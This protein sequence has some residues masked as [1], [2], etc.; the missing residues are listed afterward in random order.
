MMVSASLLS[1]MAI[2]PRPS[3]FIPTNFI[4]SITFF[5][6]LLSLRTDAYVGGPSLRSNTNP[7]ATDQLSRSLS[8]PHPQQVRAV[9]RLGLKLLADLDANGNQNVFISPVSIS[10]VLRLLQLG[11]TVMSD[12]EREIRTL[13]G[14]GFANLTSLSDPDV[15][16]FSANSIWTTILVLGSY[17]S[18]VTR[19]FGAKV[20]PLPSD[21]SVI[22]KWVS[23]ATRG[24]ILTL[25]EEF[26][27]GQILVLLINAI[28]FKA[29][30]KIAFDPSRTTNNDFFGPRGE[31]GSP[32][33]SQVRM[34]RLRDEEFRYAKVSLMGMANKFLQVVE[35]DY[36]SSGEY[37]ATFVVPN[38]VTTLEEAITPFKNGTVQA[39]YQWIGALTRIKLVEMAL[40]RFRIEFGVESLKESLQ[41]SG[42]NAPFVST[43]GNPQFSRLSSN[44]GVFVRDILHKTTV[45]VTEEGTEASAV[46][47]AIATRSNQLSPRVILNRPFLFAIRNVR[48]GALLFVGKID[49]P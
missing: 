2:G 48:T 18:T 22:N 12:S 8:S 46:T 19:E 31:N 13:I 40:P 28:F 44:Q 5:A 23:D 16:L 39:W 45:E 15:E 41:R 43:P 49:L 6:V 42:L 11:T 9:N 14:N 17:K 7:S 25:F 3:N 35:L 21:V 4:F 37:A 26:P 47:V 34:M 33:V 1:S 38:G 27:E 24:N 32:V 10:S 30:W 29:P 20:C 36:G